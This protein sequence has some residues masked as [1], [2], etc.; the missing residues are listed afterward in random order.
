MEVLNRM[1]VVIDQCSG[2]LRRYLDVNSHTFG[3][4]YA[5]LRETIVAYIFRRDVGR[6]MVRHDRWRLML[7]RRGSQV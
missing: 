7:S 5:K 3:E 2:E 4:D 6:T 1:A